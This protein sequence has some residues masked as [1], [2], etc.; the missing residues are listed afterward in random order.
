MTKILEKKFVEDSTLLPRLVELIS[1]L[2][3]V[4]KLKSHMLKNTGN[5]LDKNRFYCQNAVNEY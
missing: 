5:D 3:Y 4:L 1:S 2:G